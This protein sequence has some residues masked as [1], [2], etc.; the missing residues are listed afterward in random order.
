MSLRVR[1]VLTGLAAFLLGG[2]LILAYSGAAISGPWLLLGG[3]P[4]GSIL[5][6][7]GLPFWL[8][9]PMFAGVAFLFAAWAVKR[10]SRLAPAGAFV[11][12]LMWGLSVM[13][14]GG[15]SYTGPST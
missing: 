1:A 13:Q 9:I 4:F 15:I 12:L 10:P 8:L 14:Q 2:S 3:Q 11:L 5:L 7:F 6:F